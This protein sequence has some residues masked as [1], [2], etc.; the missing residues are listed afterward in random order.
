MD[1][2]IAISSSIAYPIVLFEV[3]DILCSMAHDLI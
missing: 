1:I 2:L 3:I